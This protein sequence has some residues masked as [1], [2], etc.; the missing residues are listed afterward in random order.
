[1]D[2]GVSINYD[3]F[4][5]APWNDSHVLFGGDHWIS[6][7][8]RCET[9]AQL[10]ADGYG[11][12]IMLAQDACLKI[13]WTEYDGKGYAYILREIVPKLLALG[14]TEQQVTAMLVDTPKRIFAV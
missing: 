8:E 6:D 11:D 13:R 14:V 1:M 12:Q 4:R 7:E 5:G 10:C 3:L 2:R 9:L